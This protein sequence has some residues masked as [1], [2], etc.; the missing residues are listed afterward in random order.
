MNETSQLASWCFKELSAQIE[1]GYVSHR[2]GGVHKYHAIKQ[3]K[4]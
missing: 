2:A 1:V 3:R 4:K